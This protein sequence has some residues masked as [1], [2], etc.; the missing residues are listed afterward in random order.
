MTKTLS[1]FV[2]GPDVIKPARHRLPVLSRATDQV[3]FLQA[4]KNLGQLGYD[5]LVFKKKKHQ[6]LLRETGY[7]VQRSQVTIAS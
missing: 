5:A 3:R 7:G 6:T 4:E 2:P 1:L